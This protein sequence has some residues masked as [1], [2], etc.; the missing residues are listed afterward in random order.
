M[1]EKM[2]TGLFVR[3]YKT[4]QGLNFIPICNDYNNKYSVF[5]GNNGTGKSSVLEALNTFFNN[6]YWNISKNSKKSQAF[7][8]PVFLLNKQL[9][10][11]KIYYDEMLLDYVEFLSNYFWN[12]TN[13]A[14]SNMLSEEFKKF[15]EYRDFLKEKYSEEDFYFFILGIEHENKSK[16]D[17]IT[18]N[19]DLNSKL[20]KEL[21]DFV[22]ELLLDKI[23]DYYSYVYIPVSTTPSNILRIEGKE[24][25]ELMNSDILNKIDSI[26]NEKKFGEGRKSISVIDYINN[27]L[28]S[29]ID[30]INGIIRLIDKNYE[31]KVEGGNG[32]KKNLTSNDVR[33]KILE[34]YFSIRTL[35]KDRKEIE[36]LSSGEQR[37]AII[38]IA[39]A[40]LTN[41]YHTNRKII[42]AIDEPENSLH[43]SK[44][45]SQFE[46]LESL[47][48]KHQV[49][50]TTHWYGLLPISSKGDLHH[51]E[52]ESKTKIASFDFSNY[53]ENRRKLPEDIM[54]KS[55]FE[56]TSSIL[57]SMR[58]D[59]TNWVICEGSDDKA[60]LEHYL[61]NIPN[62]KIFNVGGCG[63]VVK[64]YKYLYIPFLEKE[65]SE[66]IK[67]KILCI[68]DTDAIIQSLEI[69]SETRN[70]K[71]KVVRIQIDNNNNVEL[72][73]LTPNGLHN[74]TEIEDCLE[75]RLFFDAINK[76]IE[77]VGSPEQKDVL[78][79]YKFNE[80][81]KIS[82]IKGENSIFVPKN[83]DALNKKQ[84]IYDIFEDNRLK[85]LI[86]NRY[87]DI[88]NNGGH[89][90]KPYLF[91]IIEE[92]FNI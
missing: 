18:F 63:N 74:P 52:K 79:N 1:E 27:S 14:N 56:L 30:A 8:A 65:E 50:I 77:D 83:I 88:Y 29:Y 38:D 86:C 2:I 44:I 89:Y 62:L 57:S 24:I 76:V 58:A 21:K 10:I 41:N 28:N 49:L 87:I 54:I 17:Y 33:R 90:S 16:V 68:I 66:I 4:Y 35:K 43:I 70:K 60:Y 51:L 15:F 39:T 34:A 82:R 48:N 64:L 81:I 3:H 23:R 73:K 91:E 69:D 22:C 37:V 47:T 6:T 67:S 40:F 42:F 19:A 7:I 32:Y 53:Y 84:V 9:F 75:P 26:L 5:I 78:R 85:Y 71:L 72:K 46:R 45:F 13:E 25:Q 20:P 12:V 92:Y 31:F 59:G 11:E 80:N 36:E 55:Y 61:S